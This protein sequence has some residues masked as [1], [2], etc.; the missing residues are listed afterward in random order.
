ML[1]IRILPGNCLTSNKSPVFREAFVWASFDLSEGNHHSEKCSN[2]HTSPGLWLSDEL[3]PI[4]PESRC[5][6][7]PGSDRSTRA[8]KETE[9]CCSTFVPSLHFEL[10]MGEER[11]V[12][13]TILLLSQQCNAPSVRTALLNL[14]FNYWAPWAVIR[15]RRRRRAGGPAASAFKI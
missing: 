7:R 15:R 10:W 4:R 1:V 9:I 8:G 6:V 5:H 3:A 13:S 12:R 2:S 14:L 11:M